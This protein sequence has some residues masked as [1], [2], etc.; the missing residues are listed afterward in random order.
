MPKNNETNHKNNRIIVVD[1]DG[2][3]ANLQHRVKFIN[4][5]LYGSFYA[6]AKYDEPIKNII[7]IVKELQEK[8]TI[9]YLTNRP[10]SIRKDTY[11]WLTDQGLRVDNLIMRST[12]DYRKDYVVK[13]E[14]LNKWLDGQK[15][16]YD[17][18]GI[19]L[20]DRDVMVK[21]WRD[22]GLTC[23]QVNYGEF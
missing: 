14:K 23:L 7:N 18:I 5:K 10:E 9:V 17:N 1:I 22:L 20:E 21:A 15:L 3:V 2:T 19:I 8:F 11:I 12:R 4:A 16:S 6:Q 13:V